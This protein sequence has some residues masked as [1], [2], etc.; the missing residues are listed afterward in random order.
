M[1]ELII[2]NGTII[3]GSGSPAFISDIGVKDGKIKVIQPSL[4]SSCKTEL[5]VAGKVVCPGFIDIHSHTD[6]TIFQNP[7]AESKIRQGITTEIVGN[8]GMSAAP[9]SVS[10]LPE[11]RDHLTVNGDFGN[12][13]NI[14][15]SWTSFEEYIKYLNELPLGVNLMPLVGYGTLRSAVM[16]LNSG[17]PTT[18]EMRAMEDLLEKSLL[19]GACGMSTGLEYIP[20]AHARTVE[21]IKL[22][23]VLER[24]DKLY[25]SHIRGESQAL[26]T[27]IEE[28][29][30][31]SEMSGCQL[32]ISHL[33]LGGMFNW[34]KTD[35]LFSVLDDAITQG[36]RLSWDQYPY[37][38][39]GTGLA[40]YIPAWVRQDGYQKLIENLS[41]PT[42]RKKIRKEIELEIQ[43]GNHAY[44]TAPWENVQIAMV[45]SNVFKFAE[46]KRVSTIAE[47]LDVDALDLVF[48]LLI[49][50]KGS[51]STLVFCMDENDVKTI[52]KH[53]RTIIA[54]DGRAVANYGELHK[55]SPHPRYY[56]A[57]P[58]VLGQYVREEKVFLLE[59][60]IKKMTSMPA[61]IMGLKTR[62]T[63]T[64]KMV[65]DITVFDPNTVSDMAT[66]ENPHQYA[67][68]IEYV[69]VA[70]GVIIDHGRHSNK[71]EG[72][73]LK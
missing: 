22:C 64:P 11:I 42:T 17:P 2:K 55:G 69:M 7:K 46:G 25:T 44:N 54:S 30:H 10:F 27:S 57:F 60:A 26:F 12:P 45:Q 34:G 18:Y 51:V 65:A 4:S 49:A 58:R 61:E 14:G 28:A 40:D 31:T 33:K 15:K 50:E 9:L 23:R 56:G 67:K 6:T 38:A 20:D 59:T 32:E 3:D 36:V 66:F 52:M 72:N 47:Q 71:M 24:N 68:G 70:G 8:C 37:V 21:L 39:W 5:D 29:I 13:A 35:K 53:P 48:D 63:L 19:E 41:N 16:G 1:L 43:S 73:V 62:G